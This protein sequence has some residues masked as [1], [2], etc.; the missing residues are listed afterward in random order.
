M[1]RDICSS[2]QAHLA[3]V[4]RWAHVSPFTPLT[5]KPSSVSVRETSVSK[6]ERF[7]QVS[8]SSRCEGDVVVRGS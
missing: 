3:I 8:I 2:A 6:R 4:E 5:V 7:L 1:G